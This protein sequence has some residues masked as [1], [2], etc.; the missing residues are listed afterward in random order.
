MTRT[1]D[2]YMGLASLR[3]VITLVLSRTLDHPF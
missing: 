3:R 1:L 2:S